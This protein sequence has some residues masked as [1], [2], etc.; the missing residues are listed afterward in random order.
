MPARQQTGCPCGSDKDFT[1]CCEPFLTLK[2][3]PKSVRQLVRA[4][5]CAYKLGAGTWR[6]F[7]L[8]TWH[9]TTRAKVNRSCCFR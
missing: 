2:E 9:P 8:R 6:D 7:L 5:F 1:S 3:N 4:R